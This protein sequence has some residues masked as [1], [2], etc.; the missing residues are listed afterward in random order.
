M[1]SNLN[2]QL[3]VLPGIGVKR[4]RLLENAG[5]ATV[6]HLLLYLPYRYVDRSTEVGI[7]HLPLEQEVTVVGEIVAMEMRPAKRRRFVMTVE[8]DTGSVECTWFGGFQH[9]KHS[10]EAGDVVALGGKLSRFGGKLQMV[11]PE[12]EVLAN[13]GD[14]D[15]RLHT[16]RIIPLYST[17]AKMKAD[18]LTA[19]ELRRLLFAALEAVGDEICDPVP[20]DVRNR[21]GLM[22]LREAIDKI[23]FPDAISDVDAAR[24]RLAFD[25]LF[26]VQLHL[27]RMQK[28]RQSIPGQVLMPNGPLAQ[29]LVGS[30]PFELTGAQKRA[31]AE[32]SG[33]LERSVSMHRLLQGD[34]GSGKTL[35]A[36]LAMLAAADCGV[37]AA[38][39]APTEILSGQHLNTIRDLIGPL[40]LEVVLVTGR[41]RKAERRKTL[42]SLASGEVQLVVGTHALLQEEVAFADLGLVVVDEQHRFGVEQR[43]MLREKGPSVHL[44]VMTATPIP[45]SLALTLYG[46]LDVTVIDA[47]PPGRLP[48]RTGWRPAA[49]RARALDFL[50]S[51]VKKGHQVYIVYPLVSESEKSDLQ[52]A[53]VAFE[54]LQQGA[55]AGLR[56]GLLHGR[57]KSDEK[58]AVMSAFRQGELDV[59]VATTVIEVGVDVP[60]ATVMM[61]EHAERFGLS[62]LH[63]LRGRVGRG[64]YE[65]YCIL[66]A[67]PQEGLSGEARERLDSMAQTNDGF[68]IAQTDLEIRGPGHIFGTQQ[69]GFPEFHFA[70]LA[71]DGDVITAARN[72]AKAL[73]DADPDLVS[74]DLL[75]RELDAAALGGLQIVEAG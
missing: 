32:I 38:L 31:V 3:R 62:Q 33:D 9:F 11:H 75:K 12:L 52:A 27:G 43:A 57:L 54:D 48:V 71:R 18:R 35:V 65:S 39:M 47:L 10:Y 60:N 45:R 23:H 15:R 44:L 16:G 30:L 74:Y 24:R 64:Q 59:L 56:L 21:C 70:D 2:Q 46:D 61:V 67:D 22:G 63:Q 49:D 42:A 36:L 53:T 40:G 34:V 1:L 5:I 66:I 58:E 25:E 26:F 17:T 7:V 51:E 72:E 68:E 69:A 29:Q 73:L 6:G 50:C 37:Q 41:M 14:D 55:L 4:E 8:D 28:A 19:R 13:E 20:D